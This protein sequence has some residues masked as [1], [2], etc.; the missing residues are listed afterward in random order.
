MSALPVTA[1]V[2]GEATEA[3]SNTFHEG[4]DLGGQ[5]IDHDTSCHLRVLLVNGEAF[6]VQL[7]VS[8]TVGELKQKILAERPKRKITFALQNSFNGSAVVLY[9]LHGCLFH[10]RPV[11][12]QENKDYVLTLFPSPSCWWECTW[13]FRIRK[14]SYN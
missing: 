11:F 3:P 1:V 7:P 4:I 10:V 13:I 14:L 9:S 2:T 5:G 6:Q 12:T 8:S